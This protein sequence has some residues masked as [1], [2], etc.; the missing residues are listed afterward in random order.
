VATFHHPQRLE[1]LV[2]VRDRIM[3]E[4]MGPKQEKVRVKKTFDP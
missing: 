1:R 2:L 3:A 4:S